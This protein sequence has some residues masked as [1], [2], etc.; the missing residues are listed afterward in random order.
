LIALP[1]TVP[2]IPSVDAGD[3]SVI[4]P[5]SFDPDWV[6]L[7][8]KV[9]VY[10]PLYC[11][12]HFPD[13]PLLLDAVAVGVTVAVV[14]ALADE[15]GVLALVLLL[16]PPLLPHPAPITAT[17]DK[18]IGSRRVEGCRRIG[19]PFLLVLSNGDGIRARRPAK[20]GKPSP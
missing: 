16:L 10:A 18:K 17:S 7:R 11:P 20:E 9:P 13:R 2:L 4:L 3:E 14:V 1:L 6:Q 8:V 12:F 5:L 19:C 15:V